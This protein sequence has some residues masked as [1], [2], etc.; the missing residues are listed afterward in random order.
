MPEVDRYTPL[1][2]KGLSVVSV[3]IDPDLAFIVAR[4]VFEASG[5]NHSLESGRNGLGSGGNT[6]S[7]R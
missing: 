6:R 2:P 3:E 4:T 5:G 7:P 1:A